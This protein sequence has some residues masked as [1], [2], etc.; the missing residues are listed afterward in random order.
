MK[1]LRSLKIVVAAVAGL[2]L[3]GASIRHAHAEL[4]PSA[5]EQ[6]RAEASDVLEI[7]IARVA[8]STRDNENQRLVS[9]FADAVVTGM[10]RSKSGV[11]VGDQISLRYMTYESNGSG[12]VGPGPALEVKEGGSYRAWLKKSGS[13]FYA[14]AKGRSFEGK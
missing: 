6:M 4:P 10:T 3:Y 13:I 14:A 7:K 12:F 1:T 9:I 8:R 11:K 2:V 5:Y